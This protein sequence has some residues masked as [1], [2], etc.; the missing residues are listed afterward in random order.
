M[1]PCPWFS[2]ISLWNTAEHCCVSH[3]SESFVVDML[4]SH[5]EAVP[6]TLRAAPAQV[7]H[8]APPGITQHIRSQQVEWIECARRRWLLDGR[9]C[10]Y[11]LHHS[12]CKPKVRLRC[13]VGACTLADVA[14]R[15]SECGRTLC[16]HL[17]QTIQ[18]RL[19]GI[20]CEGR[21]SNT[22]LLLCCGFCG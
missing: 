2:C 8:H 17:M 7:G 13:R 10:V 4:M 11:G 18:W 15:Y 19:G 6:S 20:A 1:A 12:P 22:L 9:A 3:L 21:R 16:N 14:L 5:P